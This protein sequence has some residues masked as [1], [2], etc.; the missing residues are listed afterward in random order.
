M[1]TRASFDLFI[2]GGGINGAGVAR[3]AAG[4]GLSV[5]LCE[6]GDFAGATSSASTK[7]IHGGLR[8]L[9]YYEFR[10]V[11]EALAERE[12]LLAI[13]PHISWP[14][15]F[16]MPHVKELRPRW[17]I[18]L[19]LWLY[20]HIGGRISL[21]HSHGV[22]LTDTPFGAGLR[23]DLTRG[24]VYSD[25][26]VDDARL[27]ILNLLSA[28]RHGA[29]IFARTRMAGARRE[30]GVWVCTLE[31]RE[32]GVR[33]EISA[34]AI[35]NAAGPWV[36]DVESQLNQQGA[37]KPQR[38]GVKLV[39]GS[40]IVVP[41][42]FAGEHAYILQNDDRRIVFMIPYEQKF[43]LIGTTDVPQADMKGGAQ[44]ST[45]EEDYLLRAVNRYLAKPVGRDA[46]VWRYAGVRPLFDDESD[47]PSAVTRDYTLMVDDAAGIPSLSVYGGK[48]T[49]YRRL[50][51]SVLE[52]L[53][54]W[55]D[56]KRGPWTREEALP[57]GEFPSAERNAQL[58][59]L[60]ACYP[61]LPSAWL[62]RIFQR[63]GLTAYELLG[64][65]K[66]MDDLGRDF[67]GGLTEREVEHFVRHEWA[68]APEDILWRRTKCGLHM[69]A[70][71][72]AAFAEYFSAV[73]EA[74]GQNK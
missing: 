71:E 22:S 6:Q 7:L 38:A 8:Y 47:N 46:I 74:A 11:A 5:A 37:G 29:Q 53:A 16:V 69:G 41:K 1:S 58:A 26:W 51:E 12:H 48:I 62:T 13:A 34:R 43:T 20:D 30:G 44:I 36:V 25:A 2:I 35:V 52:K 4:R 40:H 56:T 17:M 15:R 67:G 27:V 54:P 59:R 42:L 3:D 63:H 33:R 10:L 18:R 9:E 14:L 65:A 28:Q 61:D 24:F 73:A 21:P 49:T 50:A 70:E 68:R 45:D 19:G 32:T 39:R 31:D 64:N 23:P 60:F 72:R 57:G 55:L 66:V